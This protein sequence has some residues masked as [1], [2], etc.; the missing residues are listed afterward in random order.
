MYPN[1]AR[2]VKG[3]RKEINLTQEE[4]QIFTKLALRF[5]V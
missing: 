2:F 5:N 3:K 4:F 1:L